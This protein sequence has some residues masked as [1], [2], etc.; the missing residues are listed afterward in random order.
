[1]NMDIGIGNFVKFAG[2]GDFV[3]EAKKLFILKKYTICFDNDN[4]EYDLR[5]LVEIKVSTDTLDGLEYN[6]K[7]SVG[8]KETNSNEDSP[9]SQFTLRQQKNKGKS[10]S[11]EYVSIDKNEHVL[12]LASIKN[13]M[14]VKLEYEIVV[15]VDDV[16]YT[17]RLRYPVKLFSLD[18]SLD[19]NVADF[20]LVGQLIGTL[21]DQPDVTIDLTDDKKRITMRTHNWLLPKNGAVVFHC[22]T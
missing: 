13:L 12:L 18:Y 9:I 16:I 22:R 20:T 2:S 11:V 15:P 5:N 8:P 17:K 21:I 1:M 3:E 4:T 6:G 7:V 14:H 10:E 19:K